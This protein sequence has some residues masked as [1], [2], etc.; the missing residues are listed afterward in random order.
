MGEQRF[1]SGWFDPIG[2]QVFSQQWR[3]KTIKIGGRQE[4][5]ALETSLLVPADS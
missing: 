4:F 2:V 5:N 1:R 3:R